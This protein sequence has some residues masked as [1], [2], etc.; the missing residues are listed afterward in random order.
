[1]EE[2][3]QRFQH[4]MLYYLKKGKNV[5]EM[6]EKMCAV[7]GEGSVTDWTCQK[8][9]VKFSAGDFSLDDAPTSGRAVE[10]DRNKIESLIE[11]N[12]CFT[13]QGIADILKISQSTKFLVKMKNVF[14][15]TDKDTQ[16]FWPTQYYLISILKTIVNKNTA[17]TTSNKK[18]DSGFWNLAN[19]NDPSSVLPIALRID[20]G[21]TMTS[22]TLEW[23][24]FFF[25]LDIIYW[26]LERGEGKEKEREKH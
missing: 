20:N 24:G 1:M 23:S 22:P 6:Q 8:W 19:Q 11:N 18:H 13:M 9:F 17:S 16:T 2:N 26:F 5:T 12:Q 25:L 3:K 21:Y 10:V 4:T 14:Y 15:F 7:Y